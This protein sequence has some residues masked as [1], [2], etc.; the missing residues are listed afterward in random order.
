MFIFDAV[1][2]ITAGDGGDFDIV[3]T[4]GRI[5]LKRSLDRETTPSYTLSVLVV[6]SGSPQVCIVGLYF[7]P[8]IFNYPQLC[9]LL[10]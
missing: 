1:D 3:S 6:D 2:R 5:T 9:P 8:N 7:S 4:T 10:I